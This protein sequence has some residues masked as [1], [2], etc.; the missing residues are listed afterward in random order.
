MTDSSS[1][2]A[3]LFNNN[4]SG[5][6]LLGKPL[7]E[8][9]ESSDGLI[10]FLFMG[11]APSVTTDLHS[12]QTGSASF[13]AK[14]N[15]VEFADYYNVQLEEVGKVSPEDKLLL[16]EDFTGWGSG[17]KSDGTTDLSSRLD[18]HTSNKGGLA[19][20]CL[21]VLD[22]LNLELPLLKTV[23]SYH[24]ISRTTSLERSR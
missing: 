10:S 16:A 5:T 7:T 6:K 8:I 2:A 15:E 12:E 13:R 22:V 1:P 23:S 3:T 21:R 19:I 14:W 9:K 11:G 20:M 18:A 24:H 17:N 4:S